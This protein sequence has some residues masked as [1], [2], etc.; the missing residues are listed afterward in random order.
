MVQMLPQ[1]R[2]QCKCL[3]DVE[4]LPFASEPPGEVIHTGHILHHVQ[5]LPIDHEPLVSREEKWGLPVYVD[6]HR[7]LYVEFGEPTWASVVSAR[8]LWQLAHCLTMPEVARSVRF[9]AGCF[10]FGSLHE[11]RN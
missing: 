10:G 5:T 11:L 3:A 4:R 7:D 1:A 8:G 6:F 2:S 9:E